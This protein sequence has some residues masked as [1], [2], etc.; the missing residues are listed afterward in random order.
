MYFKCGT[1][2]I[3]VGG[4]EYKSEAYMRNWAGSG[5]N[6]KVKPMA[7]RTTKAAHEPS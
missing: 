7:R 5:K 4:Y 6:V 2:L 1:V 3:K